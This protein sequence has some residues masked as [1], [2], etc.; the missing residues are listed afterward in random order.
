MGATETLSRFIVNTDYDDI[1]AEAFRLSKRL[2]LDWL[3]TA[4]A[5]YAEEG[6][7]IVTEYVREMGGTPES[8]LIG[9]GCKSSAAS[10]AFANGTMGHLLDY[11]DMGFSHPTTCI[12]PAILALGERHGSCGKDVLT[13]VVLGYETFEHLSVAARPYEGSVRQRGY[14]PTAL[15][16]ALAAAAASA[17]LLGL[18]VQKT[19]CALG[20]AGSQA[21]GLSQNFGTWAKGMHGGN[22]ARTGVMSALLAAKGYYADEEIIEGGHGF[23]HAIH[24]EG[25]YDIAKV[26][27]NLGNPWCIVSPSLSIKGYPCC[28]GNHSPLDAALGIIHDNGLSYDDIDSLAV[29]CHPALLD[30]LRFVK[31]SVAFNGKFSLDYNMAAAMVYGKVNIETFRQEVCDDPTM[32]QAMEEKIRFVAHPEWTH[33]EI[34]QGTPVTIT[35]KDGRTFRRTVAYQKGHPHNPLTQDEVRDK[36]RYCCAHTPLASNQIEQLIDRVEDLDQVADISQ[37]MELTIAAVAVAGAD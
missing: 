28:G 20:L 3:G 4:L 7:Q 15:Y 10:T 35:T 16:G 8:T 31:P 37:I 32:R 11:D 18:D 30:L 25:N 27:E 12:L 6:G 5:G 29:D 21:G 19:R 34:A 13:A 17:K 22:A 14:H 9:S 26:T 2:V 24:M 1:A 36:F 33:A 23:F